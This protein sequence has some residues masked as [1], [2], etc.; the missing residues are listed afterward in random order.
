M[1]DNIKIQRIIIGALITLI[2]SSM[3]IGTV[4]ILK[5]RANKKQI[6]NYEEIEDIDDLPEEVQK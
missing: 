2:V 5:S 3:I 6:N 4:V 1:K